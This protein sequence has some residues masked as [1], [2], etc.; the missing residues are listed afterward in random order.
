MG[1]IIKGIKRSG[2]EKLYDAVQNIGDKYGGYK[3]DVKEI[4]IVIYKGVVG[5]KADKRF[6]IQMGILPIWASDRIIVHPDIPRVLNVACLEALMG[7]EFS[8][9]ANNDEFNPIDL[10]LVLY[11]SFSPFVLILE[12]ILFGL[13]LLLVMFV[14]LWFVATF[15]LCWGRR[16]AEARSDREAALRTS[17]AAVIDMLKIVKKNR[18]D[19]GPPLRRV[20][21]FLTHPSLKNRIALLKKLENE[22]DAGHSEA[23]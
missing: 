9:V 3:H 21:G 1:I 6:H 7:H 18:K 12:C 20:V 8:H 4:E 11:V 2:N 10:G 23:K 16:V 5:A 22:L 13:Y 14:I 17:P 19:N 15:I